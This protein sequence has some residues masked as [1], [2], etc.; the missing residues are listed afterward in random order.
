[1][2]LGLGGS[3]AT[4]GTVDYVREMKIP[5]YVAIAS[6]P[7]VTH[8]FN[9]Y[10]FRGATTESARYGEIYAE[11]LTQFL[12]VKDIA[13]ISGADEY[14][15]NEADNT[16]RMLKKWYGVDLGKRVE[17]KVGDTDFTP[18]I[19]ELKKANPQIVLAM[20]HT[21]EVSIIIRQMRELG[22]NQPIFI[23]AASVDNQLISK[24]GSAAEG[25]MGGWLKPLYFDS[26]HP[27]MV[28]FMRVWT[29]YL[30][31]VPAGRPNLYDLMGFS[32]MYVVAE[33]LR[34]AG[35][36]P[37]RE[38]FIDALE[39]LKDYRVSEIATPR[40][41]TKWHHIGNLRQQILVVLA[42]RWVPLMWSPT[43]ESEILAEFKK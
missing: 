12:Q 5:T 41:F 30:G 29:E 2:I 34:R 10:L 33:G 18:Q 39:A 27:D 13:V 6:A 4:V 36:Q 25:V 21:P 17:F 14:A 7:Q 43:R 37:T 31:T 16:Q 23:G 20:G 3:N 9:R 38:K 42:G 19:L 11:F 28:E 35:P 1:M 32:E 26:K 24:A 8:P 40:T 15:K 22:M